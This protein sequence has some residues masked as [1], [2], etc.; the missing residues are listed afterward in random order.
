MRYFGSKVST[1]ESVYKLISERVPAGAFCDP[2]GGVG[3]VGSFFKSKG[4]SIW[5]GDVLTAAHY[6]QVARIRLNRTPPFKRLRRELGVNSSAEIVDLLNDEKPRSGWIT[7]QFSE[8]RLFF[9]RDNAV[10]LDACRLRI[11]QWSRD[12]WLSINERALLLASLVNSMDRVANTAG[13]YYAYLKTWYRKA[14]KPFCFEL[15]PP[16]PGNPNCYCFLGDA[17]DLIGKRFFEI[18]Y[19]D[20]PYNARNYSS[21]YHLPE[22]VALE[23]SPRTHGLS[24]VPSRPGPS[25][26]FNKP[27][28][29]C[30]ALQELLEGARFRLLVFHYSDK[31]L[32][33]PKDLRR[34]FRQ[35]GHVEE[36]VLDS[37][38]Y[39]TAE[40]SRVIKHHLYLIYNGRADT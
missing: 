20:P 24:G 26:D 22:S 21:Y 8:A 28:R 29:A 32:I 38:G 9:T 39:T 19:L 16:T 14:L 3:T 36:F 37:K 31:G 10:R 7:R 30:D 34:I 27:A 13:T 33:R 15:I 25:S 6:F 35:Y 23:S 1:L 11:A 18:L 4:Y 40:S 17:K 2:F 5:T 12:G